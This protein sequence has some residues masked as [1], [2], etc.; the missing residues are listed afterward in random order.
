MCSTNNG[1]VD[2]EKQPNRRCARKLHMQLIACVYENAEREREREREKEKNKNSAHHFSGRENKTKT[3]FKIYIIKY[4]FTQSAQQKVHSNRFLS[5]LQT[6][7]DNIRAVI[8][9][10]CS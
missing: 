8:N 2:V 6:Q 7:D 5:N 9:L 1:I 4:S 10:P 3:L